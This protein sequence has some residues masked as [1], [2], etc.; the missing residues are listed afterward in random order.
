MQEG[1]CFSCKV[2]DH[3]SRNCPRKKIAEEGKIVEL[4][5]AEQ[6][7]EQGKRA[8][9]GQVSFLGHTYEIGLSTIDLN[10]LMG[11]K[12]FTV[13]YQKARN[14]SVIALKALADSGAGGLVFIN[15][16][17]A[18]EA[19]KFFNTAVAWLKQ[20]CPVRGYDEKP[21]ATVTHAIILHL[22]VDGR[23]QLN[24]PM[25]ILDLGNHDLILGRKWLELHDI[26]MDIRN[27]C[28]IWPNERSL[29]DKA[30]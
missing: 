6:E 10:Q 2:H 25:L 9:L 23:R 3:L 24:V 14:G 28:L 21:D 15:T 16:S 4:E 5:A 17:C 7:P 13:S 12:S 30:G 22:V 29:A 27:R 1:R 20:P 11:G 8:T 18:I 19:A 26:W